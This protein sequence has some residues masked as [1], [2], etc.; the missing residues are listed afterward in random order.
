MTSLRT[1]PKRSSVRSKGTEQTVGGL[2]STGDD[3]D[4]MKIRADLALM[5]EIAVKIGSLVEDY[6]R[7]RSRVNSALE[8]L[9]L[10][11]GAGST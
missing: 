2:L 11:D 3:V 1:R 5:D 7:V 10:D 9:P 8:A 4:V 6:E